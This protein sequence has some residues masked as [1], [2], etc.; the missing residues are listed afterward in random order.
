MELSFRP[1]RVDDL[2][3]LQRWSSLP[4]IEEW[5]HERF[6]LDAV[7]A[8]YLPRIAGTEPTHVFIIEC[9]HAVGW[10]QWY[11]WAD[12][13]EHAAVVGAEPGTAGLDLAIGEVAA[14]G[15]GVGTRAIRDFVDTVVFA[16]PQITGCLSDPE[17]ANQRSMRAFERAGFV[18]V[19]TVQHESVPRCIVRRER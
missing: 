17:V 16:D 10:I 8:E 15:L 12:Y 1:L 9:P 18:V 14:L 6:D 5:W 4:H 13:P 11:R 2:A 19:R 7:R 3:L